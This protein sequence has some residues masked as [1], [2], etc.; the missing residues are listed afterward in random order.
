[1]VDDEAAPSSDKASSREVVIKV[2]ADPAKIGMTFPALS[3]TGASD[4]TH[5]YVSVAGY[6]ESLVALSSQGLGLA[7]SG[8]L[9]QSPLEGYASA[10]SEQFQTALGGQADT[11]AV[12]SRQYNPMAEIQAAMLAVQSPVRDY[13]VSDG[14]MAPERARRRREVE[15]DAHEAEALELAREAVREAQEANRIARQALAVSREALVVSKQSK[16]WAAW[17]VWIAVVGVVV[18]ALMSLLIAPGVGSPPAGPESVVA[19]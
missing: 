18:G 6:N 14:L 4:G 12:F 11:M 7:G 19:R 16:K 5:P 15:Q 3:M 10:L 2:S 9:V 17:A 13:A 1:M 8:A